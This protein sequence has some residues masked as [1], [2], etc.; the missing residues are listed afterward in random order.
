MKNFDEGFDNILIYDYDKDYQNSKKF[1]AEDLI[2]TNGRDSM[3][4][5]GKWNFAPDVFESVIRSRWFDEV[6]YN[7][8]GLPIPYDFDFDKWDEVAVPGVWNLEKPEY[9]LYEGTGLYV[10]NFRYKAR[11]DKR[12][13]LKVGGSNYETRIWI[14]KQYM[15]RH[16]GGFTPFMLEVTDYLQEDNRVLVYVNNTRKG[17]QIPSLHYDWFNYGGIH[18]SV[19]L[20][21]LPKG[22]IK[23]F[24]I[25]LRK[26]SNFSKLEYSVLVEGMGV[27]KV[28]IYIPELKIDKEV[29]VKLNRS[30]QE[31]IKGIIELDKSNALELW[32]PES[33]KLYDVMVSYGDDVLNEKIGFRT[34]ESKGSDIVLNGEKIF[35]KGMCVHE[36][37]LHNGRAVSKDDIENTILEAKELGCNFLRLTHYPHNEEMSI[38]ADRL[39]IMLWEEIPVY[40]A[41]EFENKNTFDD[42]SNQLKE[43]ITRDINRASVIIWSI[44]NENPD[45]DARYEFMSGLAKIARTLDGSRLIGASCLIDVDECRIKD[46]LTEKLDVIGINEYYGWY[47]RNFDTLEEILTNSKIG[48]PFIIT[49]TG[50]DAVPGMHSESHELYSEEY[51]ADVY[52]K[53]YEVL[54]KFNYIR[55][56]TP[57]ILYDYA[58][59]RRMNIMQEGYN[60]KGIISKDRKHK[61]RAY[62]VVKDV[63]KN[64]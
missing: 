6:K 41:L 34:I 42:A 59:M 24:K 62:Y 30:K 51:Q 26:D 36:E 31:Y 7:R 48:K 61:K 38:M 18:R 58:S 1:I 22:F 47:L 49:E 32:S 53:Q 52:K 50:A 13:F 16:L 3:C 37:S 27:D 5:D 21:E 14:N 23:N 60:L 12:V 9:K 8:N 46:R 19:S 20:Y 17:E 55:G 15:G 39:G 45:S 57:W 2:D 43:L 63:Y 29:D 54:L 25:N 11:E 35:L 56:I 64:L 4:L 10:R 40:W 28:R 33:P 44:G